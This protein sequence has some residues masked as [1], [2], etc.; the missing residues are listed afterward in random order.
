[1]TRALVVAAPASGSGKTTVATGLM[2]GMHASA[3]ARGDAPRALPRATALGSLCHYISAADPADYQPAN[4]TFDLLPQLDE[5]T[6][7]QLRRDTEPWRIGDYLLA[8]ASLQGQDLQLFFI[9]VDQP[10]KDEAAGR[11]RYNWK[12]P[13]AATR[14]NRWGADTMSWNSRACWVGVRST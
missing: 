2:A 14:A 6:R 3:I 4:I 12:S 11:T 7:H 5:A 1:V 13:S 8:A 10:A 9:A